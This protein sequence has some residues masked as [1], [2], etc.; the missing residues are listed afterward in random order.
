[1]SRTSALPRKTHIRSSVSFRIAL[2]VGLIVTV[3]VTKNASADCFQNEQN[4]LRSG[5]DFDGFLTIQESL[6]VDIEL[7][8]LVRNINTVERWGNCPLSFPAIS[9]GQN[10]AVTNQ[11]SILTFWVCGTG[12]QAGVPQGF[13]RKPETVSYR[14]R[15]AFKYDRPYI[16]WA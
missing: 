1:M 8:A 6:T 12:I 13:H 7:D 14:P 2:A 15:A 16:Y 10:S 11:G 9:A 3:N 4:V 5:I